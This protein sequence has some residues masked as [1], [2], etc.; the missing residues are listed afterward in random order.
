MAFIPPNF[1]ILALLCLYSVHEV[2]LSEES[3]ITQ[4]TEDP[5][6]LSHL[7]LHHHHDHHHDHR[8]IFDPVY[9]ESVFQMFIKKY[10]KLYSSRGEYVRRLEIFKKNLVKAL[11][12]QEL[13][14]GAIHGITPFSDLSEEEF[15][16]HFLGLK[17]GGGGEDSVGS[18]G[19]IEEA[20]SS[21]GGHGL[22]SAP[23]LP[24]NELPENFD[25]RERGAVTDV[26]TQVFHF[27]S[28]FPRT[29]T[30]L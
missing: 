18:Y 23:I 7:H 10:G 2:V 25:W 15:E 16:E 8:R 28:N 20:F 4:V 17:Y 22:V 1:F 26:K 13:D 30:C 21:L 5:A 24:V 27:V 6:F 12:H 11:H 19:D 14:P 29:C 9:A 3:L